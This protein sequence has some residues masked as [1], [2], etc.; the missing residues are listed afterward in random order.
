[1]DLRAET[2][3]VIQGSSHFSAG[4]LNSLIEE[5]AVQLKD[6]ENQVQTAE[7]KLRDILSGAEQDEQEYAQLINWAG[8]YNKCSFES[9]YTQ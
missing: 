6:L 2:L 8:L 3:K 5:T 9:I 1:M 7:M 4:L